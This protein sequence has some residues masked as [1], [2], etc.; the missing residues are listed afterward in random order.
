M[1]DSKSKLGS[2]KPLFYRTCCMKRLFDIVFGIS[3]LCVFGLFMVAIVL[4]VRFS[5]EGSVFY[6]SDRIGKNNVIFK[7]PKFRTMRQGTPALAT[8]L[9]H[10]PGNYVTP[11]GKV[12]RRLQ[13]G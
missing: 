11:I 7:M 8:H 13:P 10:D 9:L 6:W 1:R 4:L 12:L 3:L 2:L 5:S